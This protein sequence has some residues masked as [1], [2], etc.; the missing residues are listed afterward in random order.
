M[1]KKYYG[2]RKINSI[3]NKLIPGNNGLNPISL[4]IET[5]KFPSQF[6]K[7]YYD[8][9]NVLKNVAPYNKDNIVNDED[10]FMLTPSLLLSSTELLFLYNINDITD[11][12]T[13]IDENVENSYFDTINRI[14]NCWIRNN[15]KDLKKNNSVLIPLYFKVFNK[16]YPKL[17]FNKDDC[18]TFINKWFS[19]NKDDSFYINLGFDL[20]NYLSNK[21]ES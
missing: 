17:V 1:S 5:H 20:E 19:N 8:N 13:Y 4:Q 2:V 21:Y 10:K 15:F 12:N 11:L 7:Y 9:D 16:F 3:S 14:I 6:T 18:K